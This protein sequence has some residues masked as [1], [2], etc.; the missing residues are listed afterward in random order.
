MNVSNTLQPQ[1]WLRDT[2]GPVISLGKQGDFDDQH[3][4]A[5]C[6]AHEHGQFRMWYCGSTGGVQQR[7]YKI[8]LAESTDGVHFKKYDQSPVLV[9]D[10]PGVSTLTPTLL[11][12]ANGKL[13]RENG[14]LRMWYC[15]VDFA[16]KDQRH[17][18]HESSSIDGVNWETQS[19]AQLSDVYAPSI[20][21]DGKTYHM[22]FTD[23]GKE[24]WCI[25]H[26]TSADGSHW[27]INDTP[28]IIVDQS[29]E[30]SRLFYPFVVKHNNT[31]LM[32]YGSYMSIDSQ[33]TALGFAVSSDGVHWTKSTHNP[34]LVPDASRSWES[35]YNTSQ[36]VLQLPDD[37][38]RIWY[39]SRTAPPHVNKYFAIGTA[40]WNGFDK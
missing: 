29:W 13:L 2:D 26:A 4:L 37:S 20:V 8:G 5:P 25:R 19:P 23:P 17:T 12:D 39:G 15:K 6:V 33:R 14:K 9:A 24:P 30:A 34:V 22:W 21:L 18:L 40:T 36:T 35:H 3:L 31:W 1:H 16:T 7:V 32:W 10:E 27:S 11:R 28:S 38:W